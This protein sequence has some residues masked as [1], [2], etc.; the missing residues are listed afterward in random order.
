MTSPDRP[1]LGFATDLAAREREGSAIERHDDR[2]VVR[3]PE[4]PDFRWGNFVLVPAGCRPERAAELHAD[5]FPTLPYATAGLDAAE[6]DVDEAAWAAAGFE[7]ERSSVLTAARVHRPSSDLPPVRELRGEDWAAAL[8]IEVD[9]WGEPEFQRR[10]F[11][12]KR[13]A[14]DASAAVQA[15]AVVDGAVVAIAGVVDAG[16]GTARFQDVTTRTG[17]RRRGCA[18]ALVVALAAV[19]ADR[20]GSRRLVMVADP[21]GP[22]IGLYR[23]LG[24]QDEETQVQLTRMTVGTAT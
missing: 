12:G 15:G 9:E 6:P 21:D 22:A 13:R 8:A 2:T 5:A 4:N 17:F 20:F 16:G 7:A 24:F 11:A 23:R 3:T 14:V 19:A 10:R 18:A 1:S